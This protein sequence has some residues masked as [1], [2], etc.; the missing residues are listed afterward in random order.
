MTALLLTHELRGN[1]KKA[2]FA[3]DLVFAEYDMT[4]GDNLSDQWDPDVS[5]V[6]QEMAGRLRALGVDVYDTDSPEDVFR[7]TEGV[8]AFERAVESRG[9]DLMVDE[10]PA[11]GATAEPDDRDFL[12]P[13]RAAD[14]SVSVY[15][16]RLKQAK[17]AV[18]QHPQM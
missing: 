9:G 4:H 1:D 2:F 12:L 13:R 15:L 6:A 10:P 8:E 17:A 3:R 7:L 5:R 18:R 11:H 14:E 16:R